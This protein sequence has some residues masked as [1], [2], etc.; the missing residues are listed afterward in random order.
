MI[1]LKARKSLGQNFLVDQSAHKKI[2]AAI[3]PSAEDIVVE[4]GPGTGLLTKH[5]LASRLRKLVAFELDERAIPELRREFA[6]EGPRFEVREQ[7]IL[8]VDLRELSRELTAPLR[9]AGNIPYYITS[10]I[11]FKLIDE[12]NVIRDA[13]L[14]VQLEVAERLTAKPGTKAYGI[15]TILANFFGEV[16][17]KFKVPAGAFRPVPK[18][19]SA[20]VQ[21][22]FSRGYFSRTQSAAPAGFED[23]RFRKLVRA[24]FAMRRKTL[25]NN[26]KAFDPASIDRLEAGPLSQLL[27]LRA[28]A[29][30]ISQFIELTVALSPEV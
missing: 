27:G 8:D 9:V 25:R 4:I 10:P 28:E 24:S 5:L 3:A 18:V 22:D 6:A 21:V 12:R 16:T 2:V 7:D 15:P 20:V 13:T 30:T 11:L 14:L 19:D 29:L 17:F 1:D 23:E 26:L